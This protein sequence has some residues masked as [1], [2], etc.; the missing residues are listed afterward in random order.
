VPDWRLEFAGIEDE[1]RPAPGPRF[2]H[3]GFMTEATESS[4]DRWSDAGVPGTR[5]ESPFLSTEMN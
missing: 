1:S 5:K 4:N 3:G 2:Q